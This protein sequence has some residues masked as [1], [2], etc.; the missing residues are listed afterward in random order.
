[1]AQDRERMV[2]TA[3]LDKET[4]NW[5]KPVVVR[6]YDS[7]KKGAA[8][9]EAEAAILLDYGYDIQ[10]QAAEGS[11]LHAGRLLLTGGLSVFAGRGGIRSKGKTTVTFLKVRGK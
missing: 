4:N 1:M 5:S 10:S 11:H 6:Q 3:Q 8:A 7:N 2:R 9:Y